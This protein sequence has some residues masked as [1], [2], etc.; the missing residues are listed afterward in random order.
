MGV[1]GLWKLLEPCGRRIHVETLENTTLA[2]DVSIWM[3]QFVKAMRDEEGRPIKNAH[4]IGTLRRVAKLLYHGVRPVIVFD[5]GVPALKERLIR[6]RRMRRERREDDARSTAKRLLAARLR[7]EALRRKAPAQN[8]EAAYAGGFDPG[9]QGEAAPTRAPAPRPAPARPSPE[10]SSDDDDDGCEWERGETADGLG[11]AADGDASAVD[12]EALI[13]LPPA[14]RKAR[15]EAVNRKQRVAARRR[16]MPVAGD[17][18]EFS[19]T[20]LSSFLR[21]ATFRQRVERAQAERG[22]DDA[23]GERIHSDPKRRFVLMRDDENGQQ[24]RGGVKARMERFLQ[25][26]DE[27]VP[28]EEEVADDDAPPTCA[29][30]GRRKSRCACALRHGACAR[31]PAP[32]PRPTPQTVVPLPGQ[33]I[34]EALEEAELRY[35]EDFPEEFAGSDDD[36]APAPAPVDGGDDAPA[37][38]GGGDD[39]SSEESSDDEVM[40]FSGVSTATLR[41][42]CEARGLFRGGTRRFLLQRLERNP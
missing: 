22:D 38:P 39:D 11:V 8:T 26:N 32:R 7:A 5:G 12:V 37:L 9:S 28:E 2:V 13:A 25:A 30:C 10:S 35:V 4:V 19:A 6:Q 41:D 24:V 17:A 33:S 27:E 14:V 36:A 20:Q 15:V 3:T 23:R 1:K 40:D 29:A 18:D 16:L 42:M 21:G 34:D 31:R